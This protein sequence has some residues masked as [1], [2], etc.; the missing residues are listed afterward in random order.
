MRKFTAL[1]LV[2]FLLLPAAALADPLPLGEDLAGVVSEEYYEYSYRYPHIDESD[3]RAPLVNNLFDSEVSIAVNEGIPSTADYYAGISTNAWVTIDYEITL[4]NDEFF[5]VRIRTETETEED[6][7]FETW[8]GYTFSL[9]NGNPGQTFTIS[10]ILGIQKAGETDEDLENRYAAQIHAAV[11]RLVWEQ[12]RENPDG[13]PYYDWLTKE[14]LEYVL[15]PDDH[16]WLDETG[17][18]VF[19]ID[20]GVIADIDAGT[21]TFSVTF[22]EI[23]DER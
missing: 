8:K 18:P 10:Q 9:L 23:D 4:S 5:S 1:L 14:D 6:G 11:C 22:E 2:L 15:K 13:I 21:V 19:Y 3:P 20:P 7:V 12:I 16:F 17:N